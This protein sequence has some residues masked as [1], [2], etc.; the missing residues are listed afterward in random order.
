MPFCQTAPLL[1]SVTWQQHVT[2]YLWEGSTSIA[3]PP[4]TTSDVMKHHKIGGTAFEAALPSPNPEENGI[5][6]NAA[7]SSTELT[8]T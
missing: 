5:R 2:E 4:T 8:L 6:R 7:Q 1:P 3:I